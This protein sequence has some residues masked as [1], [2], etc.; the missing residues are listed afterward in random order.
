[1]NSWIY[2]IAGAGVVAAG[3]VI[4]TAGTAHADNI[5]LGNGTTVA[6][7]IGV[8]VHACGNSVGLLGRA[9]ATCSK[10]SSAGMSSSSWSA[11]GTSSASNVGA[12][13]GTT[14]AAPIN[15]SALLCGTSL[16]LLGGASAGC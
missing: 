1:M 6:V 14:I 10:P 8:G 3:V 4:G 12:L 15:V 2:R 5:G 16:G 11:W 13:N 7:P 9:Q